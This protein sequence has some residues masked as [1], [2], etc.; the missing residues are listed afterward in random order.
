MS[1][2]TA[3]LHKTIIR[4]LRMILAGWERWVDGQ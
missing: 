2:V 1:P 3:Q 4:A